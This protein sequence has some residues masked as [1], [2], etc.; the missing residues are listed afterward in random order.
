MPSTILSSLGEPVLHS[1]SLATITDNWIVVRLSQSRLQILVSIQ[2]IAAVKTSRTTT[3]YHYLACALGCL[4]I[5]AAALCSQEADGATLPF[6]LAGFVLLS[7]AR[8]TRQT[9]LT[10]KTEA[11][12]IHTAYGTL[13]EAAT[14]IATIRSAQGSRPQ[15]DPTRYDFS[16]WLRA[17]IAL[18]V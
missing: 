4:V 6:S 7:V 5:A 11:E 1:N 13:R 8:A 12:A 2:S 9:S 16:R 17:Y 18:L 14:L 15:S 10:L 3:Q